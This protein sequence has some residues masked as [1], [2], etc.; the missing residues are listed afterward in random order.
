MAREFAKLGSKI[1][2][3]DINKE[4]LDKVEAEFKSNKYRNI[5]I[6]FI[7]KYIFF[8]HYYLDMISTHM[9]VM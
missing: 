5:L 2:V 8:L 7:L 9:C 6:L 1:V 4:A 3:W